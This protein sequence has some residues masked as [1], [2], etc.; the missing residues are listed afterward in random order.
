LIVGSITLAINFDGILQISHLVRLAFDHWIALIRYFWSAFLLFEINV[1]AYDALILT[2]TF[3]IGVNLYR[4]LTTKKRERLKLRTIA[5]CLLP[6]LGVA[7]YLLVGVVGIKERAEIERVGRIS[8]IAA[9]NAKTEEGCGAFVRKY[10]LEGRVLWDPPPDAMFEA[11]SSEGGRGPTAAERDR[12]FRC[13]ASAGDREALYNLTILKFFDVEKMSSVVLDLADAVKA[14]TG[15]FLVP[16][17]ALLPFLIPFSFY[18]V[19]SRFHPARIDL[20]KFSARILR[21]VVGATLLILFN[22]LLLWVEVQAWAKPFLG[23]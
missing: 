17:I 19:S 11:P 13:V 3:Q 2:L 6:M 15:S 1:S 7:V 18:L 21:L 14:W 8:Q 4:S 10:T 20:R 5:V 23:G 12:F 9:R 16:I 22:K